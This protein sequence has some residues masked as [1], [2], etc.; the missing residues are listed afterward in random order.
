[1]PST[2]RMRILILLLALLQLSTA[3]A[4]PPRRGRGRAIAGLVLMTAGAAHLAVSVGTGAVYGVDDFRCQP[5]SCIE[6]GLG[7]AMASGFL[8]AGGVLSAIGIPLYVVGKREQARD[9]VTA[10]A[11]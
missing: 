9:R 1:M 8:V 4:D 6:G 7:V 3:H 11:R 2:P 10:G 5:P